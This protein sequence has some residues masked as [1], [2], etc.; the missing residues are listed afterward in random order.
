MVA[1]Y[2]STRDQLR[3]VASATN[4]FPLPEGEWDVTR[5][6]PVLTVDQLAD[7]VTQDWWGFQLPARF[8]D[9]GKELSPYE[10]QDGSL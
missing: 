10:E 2:L 5:E 1:E 8:A 4:G 6:E 9:E 7:V 3:V